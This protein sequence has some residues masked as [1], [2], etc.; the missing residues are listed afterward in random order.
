MENNIPNNDPMV[1]VLTDPKFLELIIKKCNVE[2]LTI[3]FIKK[4]GGDIK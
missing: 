3:G 1:R 2:H 4:D